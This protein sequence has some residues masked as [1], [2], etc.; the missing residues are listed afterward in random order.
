MYH[1]SL[2][3]KIQEGVSPS[4]YAVDG[5]LQPKKL[6]LSDSFGSD[7]DM[8]VNCGHCVR[9]SDEAREEW[10]SRMCLHSLH[11]KHCYFITLTYGSYS[12]YSYKKHPF[13]RDWTDT[14]PVED[15]Y[16]MNGVP[17]W[18]P[19]LL[20]Q[21]HLTKFFKRLRVHLCDTYSVD[22]DFIELSYCACGEYGSRFGRPHFH[23]I[24]W[25]QIPILE[26][27][28]R[29]AWSLSCYYY[30]G[31]PQVVYSNRNSVKKSDNVVEFR[32]LI[33][34]VKMF[35]LVANGSLNFDD[36]TP[37]VHYSGTNARTCFQ[38]VAK[39]IC[40]RPDWSVLHVALSRLERAF[41][42]FPE[43]RNIL[44][45][46]FESIGI[47]DRFKYHIKF[48]VIYSQYRLK[49]NFKCVNN[50]NIHYEKVSFNQFKQ[51]FAPFFVCS[52]K[53]SIGKHYLLQNL[54]RF[55]NGDL[56]L[57]KMFG[58]QLSFP[59]YFSKQINISKYSLCFEKVSISSKSFV[60]DSLPSVVELYSLLAEGVIPTFG[61]DSV[62]FSSSS[63]S[64][65]YKTYPLRLFEPILRD[66]VNGVVR[67][68]YSS[69]L[70]YFIGYS[71]DKSSCRYYPVD[72][73]DRVSMCDFVFRLIR[74]KAVYWYSSVLP[75]INSRNVLIDTINKDSFT[76]LVRSAFLD[77][78]NYINH[79]YHDIDHID[80]N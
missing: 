4:R 79:V 32:F 58:K 62:I 15:C 29:S 51:I 5:C 46:D 73:I 48:D 77:H 8:F 7:F 13:K 40:K 2:L 9:C 27:D 64:L 34:Q 50:N 35:D 74:S 70:D 16:N 45:G 30:S 6:K 67:Y 31:C 38:Y 56:S 72:Y 66:P 76:P 26:S 19:S 17:A 24:L 69:S 59:S 68:R 23:I 49:E 54:E 12:L 18:T 41:S 78:R 61:I 63:Y 10:S 55:R 60:I 22:S 71:Y 1:I 3:S 53:V 37:S 39:Y 75:S 44:D 52:R 28:I 21:N 42:L 33:G 43:D 65:G 36:S 57:P 25:S 14:Y 20:R 11:Y 47:R 80:I